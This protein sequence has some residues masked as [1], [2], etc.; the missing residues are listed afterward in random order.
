MTWWNSS[1]FCKAVTPKH[2]V[3][4]KH[5]MWD[6]IDMVYKR[7]LGKYNLLTWN[8]G[9]IE[10][11]WGWITT[12][13]HDQGI[14]LRHVVSFPLTGSVLPNLFFLLWLIFFKNW[15]SRSFRIFWDSYIPKSYL[16]LSSGFLTS[17]VPLQNILLRTNKFIFSTAPM[18]FW[19]VK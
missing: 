2:N 4:R 7:F 14:R 19:H 3:H 9:E 17:Y 13:R 5:L 18:N 1:E 15:Y 16:L 11:E 12:R 8:G 6:Q 10:F